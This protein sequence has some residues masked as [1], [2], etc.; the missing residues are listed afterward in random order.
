MSEKNIKVKYS[1]PIF[2]SLFKFGLDCWG[3][4]CRQ[5]CLCNQLFFYKLLTFPFRNEC[6]WLKVVF[7]MR[8][9]WK[10]ENQSWMGWW[11]HGRELLIE[12]QDVKHVQEIWLNVLVIL[13]TLNYQNLYFIL[14]SW[15]CQSRFCD[16]FAFTAPN[17][18]LIR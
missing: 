13:D 3:C 15:Q 1:L 10:L 7:A 2:F 6:Q 14:A 9:P 18:S 12:W 8:K 5:H 16:V 11:T 17:C 4:P